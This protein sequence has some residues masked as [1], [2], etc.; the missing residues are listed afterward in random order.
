MKKLI[1]GKVDEVREATTDD[2][3]CN[4][5]D[6]EFW[7]NSRNIIYDILYKHHSIRYV[8]FDDLPEELKGIESGTYNEDENEPYKTIN[9][10]CIEKVL[11]NF[12]M[13]ENSVYLHT[14]YSEWTCGD[15][16]SRSFVRLG[17]LRNLQD[18][19]IILFIEE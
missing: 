13:S 3:M 18:K 10:I 11:E 14:C 9:N 5:R 4:F 6:A 16:G 8:S 2:C 12:Y 17:E 19:Y 15:P 1:F 7:I